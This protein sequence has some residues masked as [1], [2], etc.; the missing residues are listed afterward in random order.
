MMIRILMNFKLTTVINKVESTKNKSK[1]IYVP[2]TTK[3]NNNNK[4][5]LPKG[6]FHWFLNGNNEWSKNDDDT[7]KKKEAN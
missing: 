3:H 2:N 1:N 6:V 7:N 4:K 5:D